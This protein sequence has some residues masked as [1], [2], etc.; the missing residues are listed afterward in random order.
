M[1]TAEWGV[2]VKS[3]LVPV[4]L[5]ILVPA[6]S[7]CGNADGGPTAPAARLSLAGGVDP[8]PVNA[9]AGP[10]LFEDGFESGAFT[11]WSGKAEAGNACWEGR[12]GG[13]AHIGD[14]CIRS[15]EVWSGTRAWKAIVDPADP[16]LIGK[17]SMSKLE[18]QRTTRGVFDFWVSAW[19]YFPDSYPAEWSNIMQIKKAEV[20]PNLVM[21]SVVHNRDREFILRA[22]GV[23]TVDKSDI[24]VP[25]GRWFNLTSHFVT[26]KNG[27]VEVFLDGQ[28]IL[29]ASYDTIEDA[30]Y[31]YFGVGNYM[32]QAKASHFFI[33]DVQVTR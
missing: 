27:R 4:T 13:G 25:Y 9:A 20:K 30:P 22:K 14:G 6:L 26:A 17:E 5:V 33:D 12:G 32:A 3:N 7:S 21:A 31:M 10:V 24:R 18:R 2:F 15:E 16:N 11:L 1:L 29:Q 19:Y 23:E 28:E 8:S